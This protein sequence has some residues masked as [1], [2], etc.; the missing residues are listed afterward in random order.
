MHNFFVLIIMA[1]L[2]AGV[3]SCGSSEAPLDEQVVAASL[4]IFGE[5]TDANDAMSYESLL[6]ELES[7]DSLTAKVTGKVNGVCQAKGCWLTLVPEQADGP[8]MMVKFKDY[9]FFVPKDIAG[10]EVVLKGK[11][12]RSLTSVDELRHLARDAGKPEAEIEQIT[13]P[14][15]TLQFIADGVLLLPDTSEPGQG[16][17]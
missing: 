12:Y 5:E 9:G 10:R 11:A 15:E 4:S 7:Q 16:A 2:F 6:L 1:A 8:E 17:S 3:Q 14:E 13:E